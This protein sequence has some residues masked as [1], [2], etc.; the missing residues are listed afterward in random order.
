VINDEISQDSWPV[1]AKFSAR[2][3][4]MSWIELVNVENLKTF[5]ESDAKE[6]IRR[7][8]NAIGKK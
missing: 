6:E 8:P 5:F 4:R 3:L 2:E 1:V 7:R